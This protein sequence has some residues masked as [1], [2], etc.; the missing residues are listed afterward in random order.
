MISARTAREARFSRST[1][2]IVFVWCICL[3]SF[4]ERLEMKIQVL[5]RTSAQNAKR[6]LF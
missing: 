3:T 5:W 1:R 6:L 4:M 2:A